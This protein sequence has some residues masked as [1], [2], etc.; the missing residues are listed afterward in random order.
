MDESEKMNHM[1]K[2][3]LT[4]NQLEFGNDT[5]EMT[6]FDITELIDGVIQSASIMAAQNR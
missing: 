5:V 4:L 1:V 3:L 6:R 2:Q